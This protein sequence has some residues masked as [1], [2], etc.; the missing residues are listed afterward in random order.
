VSIQTREPLRDDRPKSATR[1]HVVWIEKHVRRL[2]I[3]VGDGMSVGLPKA[4]RYIVQNPQAPDA[5]ESV[6]DVD[7]PADIPMRK[8]EDQIVDSPLRRGHARDPDVS[9]LDGRYHTR[10]SFLLEIIEN[11]AFMFV[12]GGQ[13][14]QGADDIATRL[15]GL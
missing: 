15:E 7:L 13:T 10:E 1:E 4:E 9:V 12:Q 8:F 2:E 6:C 5:V 11:I 3:L 14:L